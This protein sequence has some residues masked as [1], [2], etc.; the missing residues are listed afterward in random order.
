VFKSPLVAAFLLSCPITVTHTHTHT[1]K[2]KMSFATTPALK[3]IAIVGA[4]GNIGHYITSALVSKSH[5]HITA[6]TRIDSTA[7]FPPTITV[8]RVDY[9]D[10]ASLVAAL[11][12]QDALI[13]TLSV[14]APSAQESLIRAAALAGVPWILPNE[15]GMY[16]SEAA[17]NETIGPGKTQARE[18]IEALGV[19]SWIGV[20]CG[21]WYEFSVSGGTEFFGIDV[22]NREAVLFVDGEGEGGELRQ[23]TSTW[24]LVGRAVANLLSLLLSVAGGGGGG[25]SKGQGPTLQQYRNRM[26]FISSFAPT[27]REM[28]ASVMRVTGTREE[29]WKISRVDAR[30]R[31]ETARR[32]KE[33]GSLKAF[34]RHMYMRYFVDEEGL[35]EKTHG[36]SN[37][38]L[39]LPL[40][41][42]LDEATRRAV[43]LAKSDYWS[44]VYQS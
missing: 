16:N 18:L 6:L 27:Q 36:L 7:T 35:F 13:I 31:L 8:S 11:R 24:T 37:A 9:A 20:T 17:Q 34:R 26:L 23:N 25:E 28:L 40:V 39:G 5:F 43:E 42:D 30:E 22:L 33:E 10:Q 29:E 41:E 19:S 2:N 21:F 15:F 14:F 44:R 4:S 12:N 32:E 38:A 1:H 3:N